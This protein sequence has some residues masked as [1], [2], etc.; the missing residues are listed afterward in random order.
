MKTTTKNLAEKLNI[1]YA[2]ASILINLAVATGQA[3]KVDT[4]K[5]EAGKRGKGT[6][7]YEINDSL[8]FDLTNPDLFK[9]EVP[10]TAEA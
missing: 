8:T 1:D 2:R 3:K 7:V 6:N 9:A 5:P 10:E 4:I